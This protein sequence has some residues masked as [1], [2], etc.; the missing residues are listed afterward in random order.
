MKHKKNDEF[1]MHIRNAEKETTLDGWVKMCSS[2]RKEVFDEICVK[3]D[4][5]IVP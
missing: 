1:L 5:P 2:D 3:C 4:E